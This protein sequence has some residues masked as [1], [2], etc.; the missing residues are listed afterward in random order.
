[1]KRSIVTLKIKSVW[2]WM[3]RVCEGKQTCVNLLRT[4]A[5]PMSVELL[6]ECCSWQQLLIFPSGIPIGEIYCNPILDV[7]KMRV[8]KVRSFVTSMRKWMWGGAL[9][10]NWAQYSLWIEWVAKAK[11]V[12][13]GSCEE[14]GSLFRIKNLKF[15]R[16]FFKNSGDCSYIASTILLVKSNYSG[17]F[18]VSGNSTLFMIWVIIIRL[19]FITTFSTFFFGS[20][21]SFWRVSSFIMFIIYS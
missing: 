15:F 6:I 5:P 17:V 7:W 8:D 4:E 16:I 3:D 21:W 11:F 10:S 13:R 20:D 2:V 1:M 12:F 14:S 18:F 9:S 19:V